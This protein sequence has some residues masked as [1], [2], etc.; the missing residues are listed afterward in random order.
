MKN[1]GNLN[2]TTI[3]KR[4]NDGDKNAFNTL[5]DHYAKKLFNYSLYLTGNREDSEEIVQET[6]MKVWENRSKVKPDLSFN[7]Y[8]ITIA[9][10]LIFNKTKRQV[11]ER[12]LYDYYH[13]TGKAIDAETSNAVEH[14][15]EEAVRNRL[16]DQ[17]PAR[18]KQ[19]IIL[20]KK[21]YTNSEVAGMLNISE[22]TVANQINK[23]IKDLQR[24]FLKLQLIAVLFLFPLQS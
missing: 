5:F 13:F 12:A 8:I 24:L 7:A 23:A 16:I 2:E 14:A 6:F 18:R 22:S 19:I 21:G 4:L 11:L 10:N 17:L 3:I 1:P 20:R 15:D 9:R